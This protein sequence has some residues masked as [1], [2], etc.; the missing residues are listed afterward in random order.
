MVLFLMEAL[1]MAILLADCHYK[2]V[3]FV[4]SFL[5]CAKKMKNLKKSC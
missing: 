4:M 2:C 5:S 1:Y 3:D